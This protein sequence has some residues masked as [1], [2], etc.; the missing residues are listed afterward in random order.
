[1]STPVCIFWF[2]RDLRLHDN[3]G[4]YA[5]LKSGLPVVPL[6]IFD[7][8]I[9]DALQYKDDKR[10]S[11]IYKAIEAMQAQLQKEGSTMEVRYGKPRDIFKQLLQDYE[12]K[13]VH[14]NE[15]YEPYAAERDGAVENL[16]KSNGATFHLYKDQVIFAKDEVTKK[17]GGHYSIFGPYSRAWRAQL[18]DDN[19]APAPSEK[20][21]KNCLAQKSKPM[22]TLA[23]MGFEKVALPT[24][25]TQWDKEIIKHY[26]ST[27]NLPAVAGTTKMGVHLRFG[28]VSVRQLLAEA[29]PINETYVNELTWREFF[30]QMLWHQPRLVDEPCNL[31][32]ANIQWR[33]NEEEYLR[34]C[35][36][37]TGVGIVDAGMRELNETGFMHNRVRM[38]TA[39]YLV[40]NLLVDYKWG[41]AYF[42]EKL[43]DFDLSANNG[44]WQWVAGCGCDAAPYFRIFNAE[45]QAKKFDPKD[46]YIRKWVPEYGTSK[47]P[48][49]MISHAAAKER[50]LKAYKAALGAGQGVE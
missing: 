2:R 42:G 1:M 17:D 20:H 41:E 4:F 36:G 29:L 9:L 45:L 3:K 33:N 39:S 43:L 47:Y 16:V 34:W 46:Q 15:D 40:K 48:K 25:P 31:R 10:I 18:K 24:L 49:P 21:L 14:T 37:E 26:H 50:C 19:H 7:K 38:L 5:A 13:A 23:E 12:V 11:F 30:M 22:P 32:Y 35:R 44:N 6:F 27:R 8:D 28:T